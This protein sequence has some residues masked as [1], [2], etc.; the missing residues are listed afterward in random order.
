MS[1]GWIVLTNGVWIL[2]SAIALAA[3][4]CA[5]W[6]AASHGERLWVTLGRAQ[7]AIPFLS[8]IAL[9]CAGF[10]LCDHRWWAKGA[11]G[12]LFVGIALAAGRACLGRRGTSL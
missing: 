3:L 2:G 11:W 9:A 5:D 6:R 7:H 12:I 8:G 1:E 4:S 10:A